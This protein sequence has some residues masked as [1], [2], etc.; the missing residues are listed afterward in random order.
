MAGRS[1]SLS[2]VTLP[3]N[4]RVTKGRERGKSELLR[5]GCP[6]TAGRGDPT[7]SATENTPS[8]RLFGRIRVKRRGKSSPSR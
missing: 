3:G 2:S 7:E 6:L 1:L 4:G 8:F 5:V